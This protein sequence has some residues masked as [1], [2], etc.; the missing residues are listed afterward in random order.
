MFLRPEEKRSSRPMRTLG[1]RITFPNGT[2][3]FIPG[4]FVGDD[5]DEELAMSLL[6]NVVPPELVRH[7][8]TR[9][10]YGEAQGRSAFYMKKVVKAPVED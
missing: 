5:P 2:V 10:E 1:V 7:P 3:H 4:G 9:I 8:E 6:S